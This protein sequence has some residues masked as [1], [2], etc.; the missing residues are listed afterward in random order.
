MLT[1]NQK[2]LIKKIAKAAVTLDWKVAFG[3]KAFGNRHLF[4]VQRIADF[5]W[6]KEGGDRFIISV[7]SWIHDVSLA[8]GSDY[9]ITNVRRYTTR[10]LN[11]FQELTREQKR[12]IFECAVQHETDNKDISIE[13]KIVH[14]ADVIDKC[15][16]LGVIRHIW[17][18]TNMLENRVLDSRIDLNKLRTHLNKRQEQLFT[19]TAK[20]FVRKLNTQRDRFFDE[21]NN[22]P[23]KW[24]N[25]ISQKAMIGMTSD[26]I[27]KELCVKAKPRMF[28]LLRKQLRC[29]YLR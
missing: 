10:F 22:N 2:K 27:A 14:D 29:V 3:G 20:Q 24:M 1:N 18:M 28:K 11:R 17:K 13:S 6:K 12:K 15:G 19:K 5:L 26:K 23:L 8:Q 21:R 4:R 16:M 7:G 9:N 25:Y